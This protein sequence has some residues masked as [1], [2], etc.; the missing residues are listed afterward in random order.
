[1]RSSSH[2]V[3]WFRSYRSAKAKQFVPLRTD[4]HGDSRHCVDNESNPP[5]PSPTQVRGNGTDIEMASLVPKA[6][7]PERED[8]EELSGALGKTVDVLVKLIQRSKRVYLC[9][10]DKSRDKRCDTPQLKITG[11]ADFRGLNGVW[12]LRNC[13]VSMIS[14]LSKILAEGRHQ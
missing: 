7:E 10:V 8:S 14:S 11:I 6:A 1:M 2:S 3:T 12:A 5:L 13:R 4:K 9:R